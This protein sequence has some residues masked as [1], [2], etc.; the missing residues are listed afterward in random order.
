MTC[1]TTNGN[2]FRQL[3]HRRSPHIAK[4]L[5]EEEEDVVEF[6][7]DCRVGGSG[8]PSKK[9]DRRFTKGSSSGV[10][11]L[12]GELVLDPD[13]DSVRSTVLQKH[14]VSGGGKGWEAQM[15]Y[16]KRPPGGEKQEGR[17]HGTRQLF[18]TEV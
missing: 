6:G 13:S 5:D 11:A 16:R 17:M 1:V 12:V 7:G 3:R 10:V 4:A 15:I 9:S 2:G 14:G 18:V 8:N